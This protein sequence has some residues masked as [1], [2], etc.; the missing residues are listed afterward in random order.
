MHESPGRLPR[1]EEDLG[2]LAPRVGVGRIGS[3]QGFE[4]RQFTVVEHALTVATTVRD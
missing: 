4:L 1:T 2:E 3:H